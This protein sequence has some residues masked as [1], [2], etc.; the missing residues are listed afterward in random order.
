MLTQQFDMQYLELMHNHGIRLEGLKQEASQLQRVLDDANSKLPYYDKLL[1]ELST[2]RMLQSLPPTNEAIEH[3]KIPSEQYEALISKLQSYL[4]STQ[5]AINSAQLQLADR[6]RT[7]TAISSWLTTAHST[8][9]QWLKSQKTAVTARLME[10]H[11]FLEQWDTKVK[12]V[13]KKYYSA[14][15]REQNA[16]A[17]I[18]RL[19]LGALTQLAR[20]NSPRFDGGIGGAQGVEALFPPQVPKDQQAASQDNQQDRQLEAAIG[21]ISSDDDVTLNS[22]FA[23]PPPEDFS[24]VTVDPDITSPPLQPSLQPLLPPSLLSP[25]EGFPSDQSP[26]P[27]L[28]PFNGRP[29]GLGQELIGQSSV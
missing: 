2:E 9:E 12:D 7:R 20:R 17:A 11:Q 21:A 14:L 8:L 15:E 6:Q 28:P 23:V 26:S 25:S 13:D 27:I 16:R 24:D 1:R 22:A 5:Q 29:L 3:S 18:A 4:Q 19:D 10:G